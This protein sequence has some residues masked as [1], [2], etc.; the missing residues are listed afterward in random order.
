MACVLCV[1]GEEPGK[2]QERT[3]ADG[4]NDSLWVSPDGNMAVFMYSR[5]NFFPLLL[6]KGQPALRGADR[7]G[8]HDNDVNVWED[9]DLYIVVRG[10][11]GKWSEPINMPTND[12][13]GD[14]CAMIAGSDMY[15]QKGT[16]LYRTSYKNEKWAAAQKLPVNSPKTDSNPHFD[17][18]TQTLYWASDRGG[19]MDIW[20][21]RRDEV[22]GEEVWSTPK[23]VS[24]VLNTPAKEDQ[25][26]VI[27]DTMRFSRSDESGNLV[28]KCDKDGAW[29]RGKVENLGTSQY[30]AEVS[31]SQDGKT[32]W[33]VA[34]DIGTERLVFMQSQRQANGQWGRAKPSTLE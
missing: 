9:S 22:E 4:W 23:P 13:G 25:P 10:T 11:D 2:V 28:S 29:S 5:Y 21:S 24:G 1:K 14:C 15:F 3:L 32:M 12:G 33:F 26:F 27:G 7:P 20:Y 8:H 34:G 6:G 18:T 16:D 30:H 31:M 19:N 17:W